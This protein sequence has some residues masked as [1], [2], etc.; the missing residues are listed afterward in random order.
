[1]THHPADARPSCMVAALDTLRAAQ[2]LKL[3]PNSKTRVREKLPELYWSLMLEAAIYAD[4]A[5]ADYATGIAAGTHVTQ[6]DEQVR[7]NR[8]RFAEAV[9][10]RARRGA[11]SYSAATRPAEPINDGDC[12]RVT[13]GDWADRC[14]VVA[15]VYADNNPPIVDV[16]LFRLSQDK[17]SVDITVLPAD[18]ELI[19][20][21][22]K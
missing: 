7:E 22:D 2:K 4:L 13:R 18:L 5:R 8:E 12:V 15:K 20:G 11:P 21:A 17:P 14:G 10:H 6:R 3:E 1:M 19:Y 9:K 16:V